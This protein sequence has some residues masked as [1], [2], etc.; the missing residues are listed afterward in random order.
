[1]L[2]IDE[3]LSTVAL[4]LNVKA[5]LFQEQLPSSTYHGCW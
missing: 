3:R 1:M 5:E 2:Q 4:P